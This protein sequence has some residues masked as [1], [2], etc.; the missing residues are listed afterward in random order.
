MDRY[1]LQ[2][3]GT[4]LRYFLNHLIK[5]KINLYFIEE[6]EASLIII[7][8]REDYLKIK[9]FKT[10][11]KIK[12]LNRFGFIKVKY[13]IYK[14][15]YLLL[16]FLVGLF[17]ILI[18]ANIIFDVEVVHP[19]KEI[20]DLLLEDLNT[21]GIKK[22]NLVKNYSEKEKIKEKILSKEKEKIEWLE[23]ERIGTKY[24]INV[25][26]RKKRKKEED[27]YPR[28][29]IA[30]KDAMIL[31]IEATKG[32][33]VKKKYDYIK[34]GEVIISGTIK[35][36]EDEM[37]KVKARG[38]V[39]GEVWYK[40][41]VEIPKKYHEEIRTGKKKEVFSLVLLDRSFSF[42]LKTFKK[43]DEDK[44]YIIKNSI[45]PIGFSRTTKYEKKVLDKFYTIHNVE[46]KA[47]SFAKEKF[48]K[49]DIL[50]E[51]VLKK[52]EKDSKI[53]VEVFLKVKEDITTYRK[54][55][56]LELKKEESDE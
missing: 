11:C 8:S 50:F 51:K 2:V 38:K 30:K 45:L 35:N 12:V 9:K 40:V 20:R 39:Y 34:K 6:K 48:N 15:R 10:T 24:I 29:I 55:E 25:E 31:K 14:Y 37:S 7:V 41:Q 54:I 46:E 49:K 28:D 16:F 56:D 47:M 32:E 5:N 4:S 1:K 23:I 17:F 43:Y 44:N 21:F 36:K 13:L 33:V 18:C 53:R 3:T 26:E 27:N 19:K 22:F 42:S 52:T